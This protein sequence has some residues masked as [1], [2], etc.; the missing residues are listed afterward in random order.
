[1]PVQHRLE[2]RTAG[3]VSVE[4]DSYFP[5]MGSN[6]NKQALVL[7]LALAG[8]LPGCVAAAA[9]A[10]GA[11]TGVYLTSR[12][13][14][15]VVDGSV[16]NVD[17]RVRAVFANEGIPVSGSQMENSGA[18]REI[19]GKKGDLDVS[20]TMERQSDQNTKVEVSAR[21]NLA[22][23][24]QDYAKELLGKIVKEK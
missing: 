16:E 7:A 9:A 15:S 2:Q 11:G 5:G 24:D 21:K 23:W 4:D 13:A 17:R 19:Q 20:V 18:K 22:V 1:M 3:R 14:G 6:M 10:A 12:G 8:A